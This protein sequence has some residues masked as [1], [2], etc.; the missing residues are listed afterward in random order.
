[1]CLG[2]IDILEDAW[3]DG[4]SRTGRLA[5]GKV[6]SLAFVPE[7]R[8]GDHVLVHLGIPVEVLDPEAAEEAL[9]LR[10]EGEGGSA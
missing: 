8:V 10:V 3:E 5:C 6:V 1:M 7:A 2:S 9:A 4:H